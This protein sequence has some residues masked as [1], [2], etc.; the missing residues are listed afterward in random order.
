MYS[1]TIESVSTFLSANYQAGASY[2]SINTARSALSLILPEIDHYSVGNH[3][4]IT[5]IVKGVSREK[6]PLPKYEHAWDPSKVLEHLSQLWPIS[7]LSL[8]DLTYKCIGLLSLATAHRVQTFAL[9]KRSNVVHHDNQIEIFV[10][11]RIKTSA[12]NKNQPCLILPKFESNPQ[13][14]VKTCLEQY[15]IKTEPLRDSNSDNIFISFCKPYKPVG[16]QTISRWI[17]SILHQSGIDTSIFSSHS[18]R[19]SATSAAYRNGVSV[20]QIRTRASWSTSSNVFAR[21]Y[22]RPVDNRHQ[23]AHSVFGI[24]N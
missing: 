19:H 23:F 5:R 22:N 6:P 18:V 10:P 14:C 9:L 1:G 20:D 2:S 16:S 4:L 7:E 17:K 8:Q 13:L 12:L 24:D 15:L 3:P 11:D 21:F